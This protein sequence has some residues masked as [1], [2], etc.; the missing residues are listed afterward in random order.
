MRRTCDMNTGR[1]DSLAWGLRGGLLFAL[2]M[3]VGSRVL[4]GSDGDPAGPASAPRRESG[5]APAAGSSARVAWA[6]GAALAERLNDPI[7]VTLRGGPLREGLYQLGRTQEVAVLLDRRIDPGQ[8][9]DVVLSQVPLG[10]A[11]RRI[12]EAGNM[13][14]AQLGPLFYFGPEPAAARLRTLAA[15]KRDELQ[16]LPRD[17]ALRLAQSRRWRW[18][19]LATPRE[20]LGTLAKEGRFALEGMEQV[21]HDLWAGAELPPLALLDRLAVIAIQFDLT[22]SAASDGAAMRLVPIPSEVAVV[23]R[24]PGGAQPAATAAKLAEFAPG[25]EVRISGSDVYVKGTVEEHE[26]ISAARSPPRAEPG[27]AVV[28]DVV[29]T[30]IDRLTVENVAVGAVLKRI[31]SQLNLELKYDHAA[32]GRAGASLNREISIH[33][34]GISLDQLLAEIGG[35]AGLAIRREG[36]IVEVR[37][38]E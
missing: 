5:N 4:V 35:A 23:R 33:A 1:L 3:A 14:V 38:K 26:Q 8:E 24:Y 16:R 29:H 17:V 11:F 37:P 32:L 27:R 13:G 21:P 20:L 36:R 25:A 9:L 10:Q 2:A 30:R 12:A 28:D 18:D 19:D 6:T 34:E 15:M 31:A 22:F 7:G